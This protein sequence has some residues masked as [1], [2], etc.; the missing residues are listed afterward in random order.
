MMNLAVEFSGQEHP[1][2]R[3]VESVGRRIVVYST[4]TRE[5]VRVL[6][7]DRA[8]QHVA[9]VRDLAFVSSGDDGT[10]RVHRL[11]GDLLRRA[12]VP[13]GSYNV[14]FGDG[15]LSCHR[16]RG[17]RLPSSMKA[18]MFAPSGESRAPRTTLVS[19]SVNERSFCT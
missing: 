1:V 19:W 5:V 4:E 11:N 17:A 14:T 3:A 9:F 10:V 12:Q 7:A 6:A 13:L 18:V 8:P 15:G 16:C 2:G